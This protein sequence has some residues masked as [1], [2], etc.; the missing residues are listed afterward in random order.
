MLFKKTKDE[1]LNIHKRACNKYNAMIENVNTACGD[2][3]ESRT[4]SKECIADADPCGSNTILP[5]ELSCIA[6][7]YYRRKIRRTVGKC[8]NPRTSRAG[9]KNKTIHIRCMLSGINTNRDHGSEEE[10]RER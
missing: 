6:Y 7:K 10:L 3:Y 8:R 5:P 1:A 4:R 9:T 2:L